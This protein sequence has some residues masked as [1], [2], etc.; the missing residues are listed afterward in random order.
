MIGFAKEK[1]RNNEIGNTT[2]VRPS[3]GE[4][5]LAA[6]VAGDMPEDTRHEFV[7]HVGDCMYC[8]EQIVLWTMAEELAEAADQSS[9]AAHTA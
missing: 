5:Q 8:L 4:H 9:Q 6:Y 3:V 2:C 1:T 7:A